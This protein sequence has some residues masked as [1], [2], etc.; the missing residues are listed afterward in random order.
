MDDRQA[1]ARTNRFASQLG[2]AAVKELENFP[3]LTF[4]DT[5]P[6]IPDRE[7]QLTIG[8]CFRP[9]FDLLPFRIA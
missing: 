2:F 6:E 1:D 8:R 7:N 5:G 4:V 3:E 9:D